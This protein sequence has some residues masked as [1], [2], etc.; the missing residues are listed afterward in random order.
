MRN[1]FRRAARIIDASLTDESY[2]YQVT[3]TR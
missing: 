3:L 2:S 1:V